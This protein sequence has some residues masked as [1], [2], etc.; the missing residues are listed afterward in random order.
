MAVNV[1]QN[2]LSSR[3]LNRWLLALGAL[4]LAAG[5]IAIIA[6]K[7]GGK[8]PPAENVNPTGPK[9]SDI[10]KAQ[11]NIRFP[12]A[13]WSVVKQF[14]FTALPRKNLA[15]S[16]QL[17]DANMRGGFT[18]RQWKSGNLPGVPYFET[19]KVVRYNF[20][21][22]NYSHPRSAALNLILVPRKGSAMRP[23][24]YIIFLKKFG[25]GASA[26]WRVDYFGTMQ[27]PP[28]PSP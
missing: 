14:V 2:A 13:A 5:I 25:R 16:Y 22:T 7:V 19:G 3:R 21:N 8:N 17:S 6:T 10:A 20:K 24:P 11:P 1:V 9:I 4:V 26:H 23:T 18:L 27:G 15:R 12:A 28:V